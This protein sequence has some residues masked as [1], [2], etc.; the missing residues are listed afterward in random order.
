MIGGG[1]TKIYREFK[2]K[3]PDFVLFS[4]NLIIA[5]FLHDIKKK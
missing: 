5:Y 2:K 4:Y 1:E 3:L